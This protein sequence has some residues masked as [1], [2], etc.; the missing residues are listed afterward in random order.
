MVS[1]DNERRSD[2]I[3]CF[4]TSMPR[5]GPD[6]AALDAIPGTGL[7]IPSIIGFDKLATL[8]RAAMAG[9]IGDAPVEWLTLSPQDFFR[10]FRFRAAVMAGNLSHENSVRG[11]ERRT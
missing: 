1:C 11:A 10:G 7:K 2:L 4:I 9:K 8:E 5:A 3:V 6:M